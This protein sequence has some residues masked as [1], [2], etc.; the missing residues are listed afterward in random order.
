MNVVAP[1]ALALRDYVFAASGQRADAL[2]GVR[3]PRCKA[4]RLATTRPIR[5][6]LIR[7]VLWRSAA[8][9]TLIR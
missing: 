1:Q 5:W 8:R 3:A 2:A 7:S 6:Q 4:T 9:I